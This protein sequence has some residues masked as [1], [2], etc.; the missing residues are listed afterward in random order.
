[1]ED[2]N[3]TLLW[4]VEAY[5]KALKTLENEIVGMKATLHGS[6]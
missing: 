3:K 1:M 6:L 4:E 5:V 2:D